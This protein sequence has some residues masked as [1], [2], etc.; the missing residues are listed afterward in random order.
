MKDR[1][2]VKAAALHQDSQ[3][4]GL[5]LRTFE[6]VLASE[7]PIYDHP[8]SGTLRRAWPWQTTPP[9]MHKPDLARVAH[10]EAGHAVLLEWIGLDGMT[11]TASPTSGLCN[12][13]PGCLDN[14]P[15]P[16]P[17]SDGRLTA[18]AASIFHG[19]I[20]AELIYLGTKW[21]GP[22]HY[23]KQV[24]YQRADAML[25][26]QFGRHASGAHAFAQRVALHVLADRW[27]RVRHIAGV[28]T[29]R[30]VWP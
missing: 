14:L 9:E 26:P 10:H 8:K 29:E 25:A 16:P 13:P 11:A 18:T 6:A 20:A 5:G 27:Q 28:L 23:P 1:D 21:I 19:G 24:D 22:I 12:M 3:R 15:D 7:S 2:A 17:D 30:G 4:T